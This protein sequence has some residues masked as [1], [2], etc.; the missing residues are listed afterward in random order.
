MCQLFLF[1]SNVVI[2]EKKTPMKWGVLLFIVYGK[3]AAVQIIMMA[4]NKAY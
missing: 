1:V 3:A 4:D 2:K